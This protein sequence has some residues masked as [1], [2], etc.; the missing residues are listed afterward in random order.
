M[1][2]YIRETAPLFAIPGIEPR[3]PVQLNTWNLDGVWWY[4]APK[5]RRFHRCRVQTFGYLRSGATV[6]RC[7]CGG[8]RMDSLGPWIDRNS[9]RI[10]PRP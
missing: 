6:E 7:A 5:P 10:D 2:N 1:S 9:R 3:E 4:E 8:I